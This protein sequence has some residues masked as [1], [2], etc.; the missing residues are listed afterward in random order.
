[1]VK[2][3]YLSNVLLKG[4]CSYG[5]GG[6]AKFLV[7]AHSKDELMSHLLEAKK[8]NQKTIV[9]GKG[10]NC[11][12]DDRGFDGLVIIN[13]IQ[14]IFWRNNQVIAGAGYSFSLLGIQASKKGYAGLE[15][16]SG[17][18]GSVGGAV[19]MN[20][21]AGKSE[22]KDVLLEVEFLHE[23][24]ETE[25]IKIDN[26][27]FSYRMSPFQKMKGAI[28]SAT[29]KLT[30]DSNAKAFQEKLLAYRLETQP[31]K[32]KSCGCVFRNPEG[33]SAG[34]IIDSLGLKGLLIGGAKI[35]E[36]HANFF[37]NKDEAKAS[38][39]LDLIAHVQLKAKENNINL[40]P[41]VWYIPFDDN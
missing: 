34:R 13:R 3:S 35:S 20:A 24:G 5:I 30:E 28:L 29:F 8:L 36:T 14:E 39:I 1:M 9:I 21:G 10:S 18:P 19:F 4:Y 17:I 25:V 37:V 15:F 32:D 7:V 12:F 6:P 26:L 41:E 23:N 11:L 40:E 38:D 16:A 27:N 31:Y 33:D 22:T 2:S